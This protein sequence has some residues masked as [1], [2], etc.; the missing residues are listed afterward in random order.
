M[1]GLAELPQYVP[2]LQNI[3]GTVGSVGTCTHWLPPPAPACGCR[4]SCSCSTTRPGLQR[5]RNGC[6]ISEA[7][8]YN[9]STPGFA[10]RH[11]PRSSFWVPGC[12][13]DR[14][15]LSAGPGA[16][17][18]GGASSSPGNGCQVPPLSPFTGT[19]SPG[20]ADFSSRDCSVL[21]TDS[22]AGDDGDAFDFFQ[23]QDQV[24][25]EGLP[26]LGQKGKDAG[27]SSG[28]EEEEEEEA[29]DPLGIMR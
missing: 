24:E 12:F 28:E 20:A 18:W 15:A 19:R 27:K 11:P 10:G 5:F 13:R 21:D 29:L 4:L 25:S 7:S 1:V 22:Q 8:A 17:E 3:S 23:Q 26:A 14:P 6:P 2:Q 16:C 9:R